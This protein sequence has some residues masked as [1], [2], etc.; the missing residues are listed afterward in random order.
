MCGA[1][2]QTAMDKGIYRAMNWSLRCFF[3]MFARLQSYALMEPNA[4]PQAM[5][6]MAEGLIFFSLTVYS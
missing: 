5:Q 1:F 4:S 2:V 6:E 3:G